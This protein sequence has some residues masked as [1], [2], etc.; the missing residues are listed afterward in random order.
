MLFLIFIKCTK[1]IYIIIIGIH[2]VLLDLIIAK[3]STLVKEHLIESMD[4]P[5]D[6]ITSLII[7]NLLSGT[8][9]TSADIKASFK[10]QLIDELIGSS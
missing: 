9:T 1:I 4:L 6:P 7:K 8:T 3:E 2:P 10:D 5:D